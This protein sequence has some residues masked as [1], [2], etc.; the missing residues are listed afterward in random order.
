[1][2]FAG[3]VAPVADGNAGFGVA[4]AEPLSKSAQQRGAGFA[5]KDARERTLVRQR[6]T[7]HWLLH[8]SKLTERSV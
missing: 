3:N 2:T 8:G 6:P 4:F 1:M 7:V 5:F